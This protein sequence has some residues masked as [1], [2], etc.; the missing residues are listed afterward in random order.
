[1]R[2]VT[3]EKPDSG[4][5]LW[6]EVALSVYE[7][8]GTSA[9]NS[10]T[11]RAGL[12]GAYH[13]GVEVYW[14]E[15]SFGWS[16][17]GSGVYMVHVG[18]STL[19]TFTERIP[20]GRTQCSPKHVIQ[21]LAEL[22]DKWPGN[23][24]H[25]LYRNCAHFAVDLV[26]CLRVKEAPDWVGSLAKVGEHIVSAL[27]VAGAEAAAKAVTPSPGQRVS[28][29]IACFTGSRLA[30]LALHGDEHAARELA[31]RDAKKFVL[32]RA[33]ACQKKEKDKDFRDVSLELC[34]SAVAKTLE[35]GK[36]LRHRWLHA[37]MAHAVAWGLDARE[38]EVLGLQMLPGRAMVVNLRVWGAKQPHL[39]HTRANG[40]SMMVPS[41]AFTKRFEDAIRTSV[42]T[43]GASDEEQFAVASLA[44]SL[45]LPTVHG[46]TPFGWRVESA[47]GPSG[48]V[49]HAVSG[50][51]S[52]RASTSPLSQKTLTARFPTSHYQPRSASPTH[53]LMDRSLSVPAPLVTH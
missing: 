24:Y 46:K 33:A 47:R 53:V 20:L 19:G 4:P 11:R 50:V 27:G 49:L 42:R 51:R 28:P 37:A 7:L 10:L 14:L 8:H 6:A 35:I 32:E 26:H 9:L 36:L 16:D 21:I 15:W 34:Y 23:T 18:K 25:L 17:E 1:M 40:F 41:P 22:R 38:A 31:W 2:A 3:G 13:V 52:P 48:R 5:P 29:E 12:G 44:S 43:A 39:S 45:E 30:D